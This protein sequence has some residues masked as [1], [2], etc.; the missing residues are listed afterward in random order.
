MLLVNAEGQVR[1]LTNITRVH[2]ALPS[3]LCYPHVGAPHARH[4]SHARRHGVHRLLHR[5]WHHL[6]PPLNLLFI[7]MCVVIVQ[8]DRHYIVS[9]K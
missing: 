2:M 6:Q 7:F 1:Y 8:L 5:P 3:S 4:G 9:S